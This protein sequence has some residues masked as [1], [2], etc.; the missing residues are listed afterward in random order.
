MGG[1]FD[2]RFDARQTVG[3]SVYAPHAPTGSNDYIRTS[4]GKPFHSGRRD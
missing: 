2:H 4:K 3:M 1:S